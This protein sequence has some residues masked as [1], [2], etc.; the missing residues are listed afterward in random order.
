[1]PAAVLP[2]AGPCYPGVG[3]GDGEVLTPP[4]LQLSLCNLLLVPTHQLISWLIPQAINTALHQRALRPCGHPM[5]Q[6]LVPQTRKQE[7]LS[8]LRV[9]G[10]TWGSSCFGASGILGWASFSPITPGKIG[11]CSSLDRVIPQTLAGVQEVPRKNLWVW[12]GWGLRT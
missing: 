3:R 8:P 7:P 5:G 11:D 1:M 6:R 4:L 9:K 10:V 2:A 12:G